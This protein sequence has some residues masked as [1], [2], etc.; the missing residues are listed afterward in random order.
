[1]GKFIDTERYHSIAEDVIKASNGQVVE[2]MIIHSIQD[3]ARYME[4]TITQYGR[5]NDL[6][7]TVRVRFGNKSGVA[8]TNCVTKDGLLEVVKMAEESALNAKEDPFLPDPEEQKELEHEQV[9]PAVA[10]MGPDDK[11]RFLGR[12]FREFSEDF[13]FHGVLRSSLN[14][15]GIFNNLGLRADF[16]YTA[17]N[18]TMIVED[19]EEKD[20]FWL[21]HT[22][23]DLDSLNYEKY[24]QRIREFLKMAYPNVHVKPGKYTV[25]LSPYALKE[26]LNF[27]QYVGFS[28]SALEMGISFLKGMEGER[29]FA[30]SF[31]LED[32]PLR[33]ENFSMPFDFEGVKKKNLTIFENGVFK[34]F[35]YDKKLAKKLR[36]KTTGHAFDPIN[37]FP[38]AGHLELK[39][40]E[41]S[42]QELIE[43]SP[44]VI[45]ITRLHYV[46]VLDP[47]TFTL[48]G[49][50]RD[51]TFR[52]RH[53]KQWSRL[54]NLRFHVSFKELFN[55]ITGISKEREYVGQPEFYSLD[56]PSA[57]LLPYVRCE[58]FNVIGFSTEEV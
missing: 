33:K 50:T 28:A 12:V 20:T 18:L 57:D 11:C 8:T 26:V 32:R 16:S 27:M 35:I 46:N 38:M 54:P 47:A 41:K 45:Y 5:I 1:M 21:Q 55:S 52:V 43:E 31:T 36:K 13:I 6:S 51:G 7:V 19:A 10:E 34:H 39:G 49:M 48:T 30:E 42:V 17:L 40:G 58:G 23:P 25:I 15:V 22:S 2:V 29:V 9:D 4:S 37:S 53:G 14:Y 3:N 24:S 56:L 44:D